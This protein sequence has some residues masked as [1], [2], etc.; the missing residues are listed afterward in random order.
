MFLNAWRRL[1]IPGVIAVI[2]LVF[3]MAGG[4][5][6]AKKY[7]ITSTNQIKPSV[8][9][10]LTGKPGATGPQG[11]KGDP[12]TKGD[13]GAQGKEGAQGLQGKSGTNGTN[14]VE[15]SPWTAGG[16]LPSEATET[17]AWNIALAA[18]GQGETTISFALP[19][20]AELPASK[21]HIEP[22][23]FVG[24]P[25]TECPGKATAPAAKPGSL[26]L[27]TGAETG[28]FEE[29]P[30]ILK[31]DSF[32]ESDK[33]SSTAGAAIVGFVEANTHIKGSWAVTAE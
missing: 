10:A 6:A 20:E 19:L 24:T 25:G 9:K 18:G 32:E 28:G 33:G 22:A 7:V 26:C 11:A 31:L 14:G 5:Y 8:L 17:G 27:Y 4:A 30:S 15:G 12:G 2:A 3:A 23:G 13:A 16:F 21:V 1:G 29:A